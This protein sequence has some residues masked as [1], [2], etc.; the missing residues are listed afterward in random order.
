MDKLCTTFFLTH[1][2]VY[3]IPELIP[4]P[5]AGR[6]CFNTEQDTLMWLSEQD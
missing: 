5:Q 3:T 2:I 4:V 6:C 1:F